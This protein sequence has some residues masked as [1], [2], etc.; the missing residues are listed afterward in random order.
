MG[1]FNSKIV[2]K[3][4]CG[5]HFIILLIIKVLF[6]FFFNSFFINSCKPQIMRC[7]LWHSNVVTIDVHN[8][9]NV[10]N[11]KQLVNYKKNHV[12]FLEKHVSKLHLTKYI[13][14]DYW[15]K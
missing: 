4:R 13:K 5:T 14:L 10:K 15:C 2:G 1:A 8:F 11:M 6:F 7:V 9:A 3:S 12:N